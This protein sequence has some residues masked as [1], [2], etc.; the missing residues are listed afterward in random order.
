MALNNFKCNRLMPLHF[1]GLNMSCYN[2]WIIVIIG[3][4]NWKK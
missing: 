3:R 1:K 2:S 4:E